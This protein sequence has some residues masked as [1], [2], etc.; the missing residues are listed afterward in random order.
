MASAA[1]AQTRCGDR[2]FMPVGIDLAFCVVISI[3]PVLGGQFNR[4]RLYGSSARK[5]G[6]LSATGVRSQPLLLVFQLGRQRLAEVFGR[7]HLANLDFGILLVRVRA[8][9]DP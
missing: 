8:A 3:A 6:G 9:L 7:E 2:R 1:P 4:Y 5:S